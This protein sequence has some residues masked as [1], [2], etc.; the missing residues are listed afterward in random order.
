MQ[1]AAGPGHTSPFYWNEEVRLGLRVAFT[2]TGAGNLAL[3]VGS[4]PEGVRGNRSRLEDD[5]GIAA[6]SL[7][8]MSQTHSDRVAVVDGT[9]DVPDADGMISPRGTEPLAVLVADCVPIV[10]ADASPAEGGTGATAVVHAGRAGVG[11]GIIEG[12]VR[13]L[14]GLGARDLSAWIGPSVCGACYEVPED[15]MRAMARTLPEAAARTRAGTPALDLPAAVRRQL[16]QSSVRVEPVQG[17]SCTLE[18]PAL[19][20]HRREPGAGRIAGLV[21]RA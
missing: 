21:W 18:N 10:L 20:S 8:F 7:R 6:G 3:H 16:E 15:M 2:S 14:R 4:D 1:A 17:A 5:M 19:Y 11:N 9:A 12:A 13:S